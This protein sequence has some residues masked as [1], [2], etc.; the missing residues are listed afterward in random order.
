MVLFKD[1]KHLTNLDKKEKQRVKE[2][3]LKIKENLIK[4]NEKYYLLYMKPNEDLIKAIDL[5]LR[6]RMTLEHFDVISKVRI[7]HYKEIDK[8]KR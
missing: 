4:Q 1:T 8:I 7:K 2:T 3:L 6:N 5:V